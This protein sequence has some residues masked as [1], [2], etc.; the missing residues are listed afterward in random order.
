[1][2]NVTCSQ[3][4]Q[5]RMQQSGITPDMLQI[6]LEFGERRWSHSRL[7][8]VITDR[9]LRGTQYARF[10]DRLRGLCVVTAADGSLVTL[11]WLF[12]M[13]RPGV[14]RKARLRGEIE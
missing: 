10:A 12:R 4:C 9:C 7:C 8:Y 6:A 1:M 13:T 5:V 14:L 3:H 11:K 2:P